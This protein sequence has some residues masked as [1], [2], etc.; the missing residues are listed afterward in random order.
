MTKLSGRLY[1][2]GLLW[3][4]RIFFGSLFM[5]AAYPKIMHPDSFALIIR[6][7]QILPDIFSPIPAVIIPWLEFFTGLFLISG[8]LY[9]A[10]RYWGLFLYALFTLL[11]FYAALRGLDMDCGCV[12]SLL[13]E[14]RT[15]W[16]KV[17]EN[18]I[19]LGLY[20]FSLIHKSIK[21]KHL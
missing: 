14:S 19:L 5:Y 10:A 7:Y 20:Y 6:G 18:T 21:T 11:I 2:K 9:K 3:A 1:E 13:A 4:A 12:V 17:S 8:I 15:G 16:G